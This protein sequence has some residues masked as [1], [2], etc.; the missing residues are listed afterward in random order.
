MQIPLFCSRC[1]SQLEYSEKSQRARCPQ[2]NGKS[3]GKGVKANNSKNPKETLTPEQKAIKDAA[4]GPRRTERF[5]GGKGILKP[6]EIPEKVIQQR[7][8]ERLFAAGWLVVRMNSGRMKTE[9]GSYLRAYRIFGMEPRWA[10]SGLPDV[11][12]LRGSRVILIE[13]KDRLGQ[14]RDSQVRFIEFAARFKVTVHVL[15]D[16]QSADEITSAIVAREAN[17]PT[18]AEWLRL[19][20]IEFVARRELGARLD[21]LV[22]EEI[23]MQEQAGGE[24]TKKED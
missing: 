20:V 22:S 21:E 12:A 10:S 4:R 18:R 5:S 19:R 11:I 23:A 7:I 3:N 16:W 6:E 9:T 15:R 24:A 2:C 14:L 13:V 8:M 1:S 17:R